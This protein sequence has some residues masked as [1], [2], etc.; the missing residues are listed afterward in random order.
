LQFANLFDFHADTFATPILLAAFASIFARRTGWALAW[1]GLL[2]LVK[3]DMTLVALTF[4]LYVAAV[5]R[6][7]SGLGLAVTAAVAFVLLIVVLIRQAAHAPAVLCGGYHP[8]F[9]T[10]ERRARPRGWSRALQMRVS[11][12]CDLGRRAGDERRSLP[13]VQPPALDPRSICK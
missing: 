1:A 12:I 6:R 7:P 8:R 3:E 2:M 10:G 9:G 5:H 11:P 4:G 13:G